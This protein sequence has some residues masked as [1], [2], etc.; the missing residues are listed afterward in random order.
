MSA[1]SDTPDTQYAV[2]RVLGETTVTPT[3]VY[4]DGSIP[5][6]ILEG[7]ATVRGAEPDNQAVV[8]GSVQTASARA[9]ATLVLDNATLGPNLL[10]TATSPISTDGQNANFGEL[11]VLPSA[12]GTS[13]NGSTL[14]VNL[15]ESAQFDQEG[16]V[17]VISPQTLFNP[18]IR[19]T[20]PGVLNND[21]LIY[22]GPKSG[23]SFEPSIAGSGTVTV[24]S[25]GASFSSEAG[26]QLIDLFG[27]TLRPTLGLAAMI[28]DWND[29]GTVG[30]ADFASL[31]FGRS[32]GSGVTVILDGTSLGAPA[33]TLDRPGDFKDAVSF[34]DSQV[35]LGGLP[36]PAGYSL[37]GGMLWIYGSD[38]QVIDALR[39]NDTS[40]E[41]A[42]PA[43]RL[44]GTAV[45]VVE[46]GSA[47]A[48][49]PEFLGGTALARHAPPPVLVSDGNTGQPVT[50]VAVQPYAGPV[51]RLQQ[52]AI[53]ITAQNLN[54]LATAP[55][56]FIHTGSGDDAIQVADGTNLLDGGAG[57]SF[58]TA[59]MGSDTVFVDVRSAAADTWST[60]V[61]FHGS[62]AATL[63][64]ISAA[65][66]MQ[67]ADNQGA[68]TATGLMLHAGASGGSTTSLTLA[69]FSDYLYL[70]A[71]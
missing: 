47:P 65:N 30:F 7:T 28:K 13:D 1:R 48:A 14:T 49:D 31:E 22:V 53:A 2:T 21:G 17:K 50:G 24:D 61:K 9:G 71:N 67:W 69:G 6:A 32:V 68:A 20:G 44:I 4:S 40:P 63:W 42:N 64:G 19:F 23:A 54:V 34:K 55:N 25:G 70:H 52:Q 12:G 18:T 56:L 5:T 58:L 15:G 57:S 27:G 29:N 45:W 38:G 10:R 51:A 3:E 46:Q 43:L 41:Q 62:D 39:L 35:V 59:G 37:A 11:D 8:L 60:V 16:T 33:L 26:T 66:P 36:G